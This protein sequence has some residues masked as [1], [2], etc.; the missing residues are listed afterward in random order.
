MKF[1]ISR[2]LSPESQRSFGR[3][4]IENPYKH[5]IP[6]ISHIIC[7]RELPL[8]FVITR[9]NQYTVEPANN[10]IQGTG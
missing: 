7:Y 2:K 4:E 9:V 8:Y 1:I 6:V 3:L 5:R 10:G